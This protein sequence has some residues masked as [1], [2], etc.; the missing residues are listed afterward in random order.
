MGIK[1][2]II[3]RSKDATGSSLRISSADDIARQIWDER[4]QDYSSLGTTLLR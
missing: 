2:L 4:S 3:Q 1:M